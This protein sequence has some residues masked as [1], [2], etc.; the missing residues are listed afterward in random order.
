MLHIACIADDFTGA[1]DAASFL[2]KSGLKTVYVNGDC[3][4]KYRPE[5][6]VEALV[7]AMKCRSIEAALA[8]EKVCAACRWCMEQEA[9]HIYYKFCSTFD[10][11]E[12]GNIGPVV[13]ALMELCGCP[14]TVLCPALPINGRT[15]KD[16]ILYVN[17]VP[18][19]ESSMRNHPL[20]PM[21]KSYIPDLMAPQSKY[22]CYNLCLQ[23]LWDESCQID[24]MLRRHSQN[25]EHFT[26]AVD[27][28]QDSDGQRIA[29]IFGGLK[30]LSG[31]SGLLEHLGRLWSGENRR[32]E[33]RSETDTEISRV[34]LAGSCSEMTRRQI[35]VY[36]QQ[37]G[38]AVR[39]DPLALLNGSQSLEQL[40]SQLIHAEEDILFYSSADTKTVEKNQQ[41][42]A[43]HISQLLES[44]MSILAAC[45]LD[46]GKT[47]IIVAG[48]ET[49]GKVMQELGFTAYEILSDAAPGIPC[50]KPVDREDVYLILKS[51]NFGEEDFFL[52]ALN[53]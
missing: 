33:V 2:R 45:A 18:L 17:G 20:N 9:E 29:A 47:K 38:K 37:G 7:I 41:L 14:Y 39:I 34:L 6:D 52:T 46:C 49:S 51:G 28:C 30:V 25:S 50:M 11:T 10:S 35:E 5:P 24:E 13:D 3:L 15:V 12:R 42:G 36:I 53:P 8:I 40:K 1:G 31:G 4:E 26:I 48:G 19:E 22:P 32:G 27:Y 16:G 44:T 23:E 43:K 21:C